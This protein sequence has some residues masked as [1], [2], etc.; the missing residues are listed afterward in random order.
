MCHRYADSN[1]AIGISLITR[2]FCLKGIH[3]GGLRHTVSTGCAQRQ[4]Q[5]TNMCVVCSNS[6][7]Y[8][9]ASVCLCVYYPS[10]NTG[11]RDSQQQPCQSHVVLSFIAQFQ[12]LAVDLSNGF[13]VITSSSTND[14]TNYLH[15]ISRLCCRH[16]CR[17]QNWVGLRPKGL[18]KTSGWMKR[19]S[20]TMLLRTIT[21]ISA[22]DN[23]ICFVVFVLW[24]GKSL[25]QWGIIYWE[26]NMLS[27]IPQFCHVFTDGQRKKWTWTRWRLPWCWQVSQPAHWSGVHLSKSTVG[28]MTIRQLLI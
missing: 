26:H 22:L 8:G 13:W 20:L 6:L 11:F 15:M 3:T 1:T 27:K 2:I 9:S 12:L 18:L 24:P 4:L 5:E 10:Y 19:H 17:M 28:I 25:S 21:P 16:C 7:S 14:K 23:A